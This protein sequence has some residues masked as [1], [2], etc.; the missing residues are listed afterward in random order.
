MYGLSYNDKV[1]PYIDIAYY[2][3]PIFSLL[4]ITMF[5]VTQYLD[6]GEKKKGLLNIVVFN[7]LFKFLIS[8]GIVS[9]YQ[10]FKQ[11][12]DGVFVIPFI[13]IYVVFTVFEAY[14]MSEQAR[15]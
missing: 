9:I 1:S 5:F 4:C 7:V 12:E 15:K 8:I 13:I 14:F 3:I 10:K 11:I 6:N 2:A